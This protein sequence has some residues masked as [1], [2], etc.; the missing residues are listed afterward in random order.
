V[1][2]ILIIEAAALQVSA[3][4]DRPWRQMVWTE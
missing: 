2:R 3:A 4:A 1:Q